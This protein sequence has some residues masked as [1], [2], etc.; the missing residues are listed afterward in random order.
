MGLAAIGGSTAASLSHRR[1]HDRSLAGDEISLLLHRLALCSLH[2]LAEN[3]V[4]SANKR[5]VRFRS[6]SQRNVYLPAD[7]QARGAHWCREACLF[8]PGTLFAHLIFSSDARFRQP[9]DF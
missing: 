7:L 6:F 1:L 4:T 3:K 2:D 9:D 8:D 5:L